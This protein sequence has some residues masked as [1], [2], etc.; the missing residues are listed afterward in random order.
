MS[1]GII[2]DCGGVSEKARLAKKNS[3]VLRPIPRIDGDILPTKS[4]AGRKKKYTPTKI[5][6]AINSYFKWCEEEDEL[7]SIKGMMI[8]LKMY[9]DQFYQYLQY[10]EYTNIME[11]ARMIIAN[12]VETDIYNTKG[13]AA[14]KI[15]YAKN[16]HGWSDKLETSNQTTQTVISV[17]QAR[18]KIEAL[19]PK[20][21]ELMKSNMLVNQLGTQTQI[22][23]Q[24]HVVDAE[25]V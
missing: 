14:G 2:E 24:S 1:E 20:L 5:K 11:H 25:V 8:H 18:A 15:A 12:W 7:P 21:L 13:M 10:P 6:N 4:K 9:K 23:N 19:A 3:L 16:L 22:A 17:D